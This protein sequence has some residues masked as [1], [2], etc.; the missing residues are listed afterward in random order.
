MII[1][2]NKKKVPK[3]SLI[4]GFVLFSV[5]VLIVHNSPAN[6]YE[7]SIYTH[8]PE[9]FWIAIVVAC[10]IAVS[11]ILHST[12]K[13]AGILLLKLSILTVVAL[14][15]VRGYYYYGAGDG[16]AHWGI[17]RDLASDTIR[18]TDFL[19]PGLHTIVIIVEQIT[20]IPFR[21]LLLFLVPIFVLCFSLFIG[22]SSRYL[23]E[24]QEAFYFGVISGLLLLPINNISSH[25]MFHPSTLTILYSSFPLYIIIKEMGVNNKKWSI[26][27]IPVLLATILFHPQ[28]AVNVFLFLSGCS[29]FKLFYSPQSEKKNIIRQA[30]IQIF[31]VFIMI[32][33]WISIHTRTI[34]SGLIIITSIIQSITDVLFGQTE[35]EVAASGSLLQAAGIS[36]SEL[37]VKIFSL[38]IIY[39]ILS[40]IA[41]RW[42]TSQFKV[43]SPE[44]YAIIVGNMPILLLFSGLVA[45]DIGQ[46][47]RYFAFGMISISVLGTA[48]LYTIFRSSVINTSFRKSVASLALIMLLVISLPVILHSPYISLPTSHVTDKE[49]TGFQ[50]SIEWIPNEKDLLG[51]RSTSKR[52]HD[53]IYGHQRFSQDRSK[54]DLQPMSAAEL[55]NRSSSTRYVAITQSDQQRELQLFR[56]AEYTKAQITS[57]NTSSSS[58]NVYTNGGISVYEVG[59]TD[60][61]N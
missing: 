54:N 32:V 37:A 15:L 42:A 9:I 19:Y 56:E 27:F 57:Y 8:S 52:H 30:N 21:L 6:T 59:S 23:L 22:L 10:S 26:L 34:E 5:G 25:L 51:I 3:A 46:S 61:T 55:A 35:S 14:P 44:M 58:N 43:K 53:V 1:L 2:A 13:F 33:G 41:L 48:G 20:K 29:L 16:L 18:M 24:D 11:I 60:Q 50:Q 4:L 28:Q 12:L 36:I 7:L 40:V 31:L 38:N 17:V 49:H 39:A 47:L 45:T